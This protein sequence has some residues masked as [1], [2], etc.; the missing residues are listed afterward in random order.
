MTRST[1]AVPVHVPAC[2]VGLGLPT[3]SLTMQAHRESRLRNTM[4]SRKRA[5]QCEHEAQAGNLAQPGASE[6]NI[7]V[8]VTGK[9]VRRRL[10]S[11]RTRK[12]SQRIQVEAQKLLNSPEDD[13]ERDRCLASSLYTLS[14]GP[15]SGRWVCNMS[16][17]AFGN[18]LKAAV[19]AL[20][21][22]C[23]CSVPERSIGSP[24]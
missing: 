14:A 21:C 2:L 4:T 3:D 12:S 5:L 15:D 8:N 19:M 17:M 20:G 16:A 23:G 10:R 7:V 1:A 18:R 13:R 9:P 6:T 11:K 22:N 24:L